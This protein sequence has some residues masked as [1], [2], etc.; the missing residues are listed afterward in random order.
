MTQHKVHKT[1]QHSKEC[2]HACCSTDTQRMFVSHN[3]KPLK[4]G[5]T[6]SYLFCQLFRSVWQTRRSN[7]SY[8]QNEQWAFWS[9]WDLFWWTPEHTTPTTNVSTVTLSSWWMSLFCHFRLTTGLV[10]CGQTQLRMFPDVSLYLIGDTMYWG[11]GLS[12]FELASFPGSCVCLGMRLY[13]NITTFKYFSI[14][15]E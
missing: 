14:F 13:E 11:W 8:E 12:S 7:F 4:Y 5:I 3:R 6:I 9:H 1:T 2:S 15:N 10:S